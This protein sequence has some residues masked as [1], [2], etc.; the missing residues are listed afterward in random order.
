MYRE[1]LI[2]EDVAAL[3]RRTA[4]WAAYLQL[5]HL[6]TARKPTAEKR[7]VLASLANRSRLVQEYLTRHVL[8]ELSPDLQDFLI[9]TSVLRRPTVALCDELLGWEQGSRELLAE[10]E[11]RQL[12]TD[13]LDDDSYRYHTVLLSY[14]EARLVE[15]VGATAARDEHRR[16]RP[17]PGAGRP[18]RG[19]G[20]RVRQGGGLGG[21]GTQPG[22]SGRLGATAS[23]GPG[24]RP[25]RRR[26]SKPTPCC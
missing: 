16:A 14:L 17:A 8:A 26:W 18:H 11:R 6:A 10:L 25:C 24:W 20:R 15:T 4:G 5:F 19:R 13:R 1:P 22:P 12:F 7:R 3:A 21:G 23:A 9:R 2:P